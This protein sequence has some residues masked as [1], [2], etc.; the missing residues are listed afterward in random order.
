MA[1]D[2]ATLPKPAH[3]TVRVGP[4]GAP[5]IEAFRC[6]DCDAV[7]TEQTIGCRACGSRQSP[8]AFRSPE[9]GALWTWSVV[10]RSYPGIEV[11]FVSAIVDLDGGL[12]L[13]GTVIGADHDSLHQ[14]M[15]LK[16]VFDDAGGARDKEGAPYI[17]F[18]FIPE[19][20]A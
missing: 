9:A 16:L 3:I 14:G 2:T 19:G 1:S 13:K 5:N 18:H 6:G 8:Q 11:P 20:D 10:Y 17:G 7:V 12:T 4:D 15:R